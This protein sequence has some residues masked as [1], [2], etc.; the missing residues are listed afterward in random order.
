[1]PRGRHRV[2]PPL[3]RLITPLAIAG[4]ASAVAVLAWFAPLDRHGLYPRALVAAAALVACAGAL[5][6]RALLLPPRAAQTAVR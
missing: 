2:S 5:L 4:S 1:M 3:H 6:L